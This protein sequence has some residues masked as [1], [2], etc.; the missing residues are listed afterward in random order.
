[1]LPS[2]VSA[3]DEWDAEEDDLMLVEF[4]DGLMCLMAAQRIQLRRDTAA[5]WKQSNHACVGIKYCE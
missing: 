5:T 1:M 2:F 3:E 4:I